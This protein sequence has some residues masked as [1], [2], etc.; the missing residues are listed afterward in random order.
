[1]GLDER[2]SQRDCLNVE[3]RLSLYLYG[4]LSGVEEES[5][6]AH[7]GGCAG[8]RRK[9]EQEKAL[10]RAVDSAAVVPPDGML[11]SCRRE[12]GPAIARGG[13]RSGFG[14]LGSLQLESLRLSSNW[15]R[16]AGAVALVA[17]GFLGARLTEGPRTATVGDMPEVATRVQSVERAADGNVRVVVEQARENVVSGSLDD[18]AIRNLLVSAVTDPVEPAVRMDTL[19][20]LKN[21]SDL[22]EVREAIRVAAETD[23]ND[24]VRLTAL[25]A[26]GPFADEPQSRQV[27]SR[28]LL[29][30]DNESLRAVAMDMLTETPRPDVVGVLQ[31]LLTTEDDA[32]LRE[33]GQQVLRTMNASLE[34]F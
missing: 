6:R 20:L 30:D 31:D 27:L 11:E 7:L 34:T 23:P 10:H 32:Y 13:G 17:I 28:V 4:E 3:E 16:P 15:L 22:E 25:E 9:L 21:R 1:M 33:R 19:A 8:C 2:D 14:W 12:L 29:R 5:L 24:A 26:L 18:P